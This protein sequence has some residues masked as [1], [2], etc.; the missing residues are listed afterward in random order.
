MHRL[1]TARMCRIGGRGG[2]ER[3]GPKIHFR[4]EAHILCEKEH[5]ERRQE[6]ASEVQTCERGAFGEDRVHDSLGHRCWTDARAQ[7]AGVRT[8]D[9]RRPASISSASD[10]DTRPA[11]FF[12]TIVTYSLPLRVLSVVCVA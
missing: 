6:Q 12:A 11:S 7:R 3:S 9:E 8:V 5:R 4:I 2:R 1:L 10:D